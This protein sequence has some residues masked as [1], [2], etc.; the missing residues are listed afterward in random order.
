MQIEL[1]P[2]RQ[3]P[4]GPTA[5]AGAAAGNGDLLNG[6]SSS[7]AKVKG[8]TIDRQELLNMALLVLLYAI[9][10]IPLGLTMGAM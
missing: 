4:E 8:S 1:E 10:G 3:A 2:L 6:G 7:A 5:A 9:Q